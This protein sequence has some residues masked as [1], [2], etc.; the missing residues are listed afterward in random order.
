MIDGGKVG[1]FMVDSQSNQKSSEILLETELR[2]RGHF[3]PKTL[4]AYID[5]VL[6]G[7]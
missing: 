3:S 1:I 2:C 5:S 6:S 4:E 7:E